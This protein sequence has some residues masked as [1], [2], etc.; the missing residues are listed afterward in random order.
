MA[1]TLIHAVAVLVLTLTAPAVGAKDVVIRWHG[2]SFFEITSPEGLRIV[3]DPHAIEEY[4]R[5]VVKGDLILMSHLHND[6]TQVGVVED[7][8]KV[9]QINALKKLDDLGQRTTWNLVDE[10]VKDVKFRTVGTYHDTKA[11]MERGK[12]GVW[13]LEVAGLKIVHLGDLGHAL[14][15]SQ[16]RKIGEVDVLM[17][18]VGGV[19]TING[20]DA[21]KVCEQLKPKRYV[22]PMHYGTDVYENLLSLDK[23]LFLDDQ[24]IGEVK[25]FPTTN[26]LRIDP[27]AKPPA[28]PIIAILN[29]KKAGL[30]GRK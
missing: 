11:G 27:K 30:P 6:H 22:I 25:R 26:E 19:Y 9:R 21:Q 3:L 12:N 29:W 15:R 13:I 5:I 14:T 16:I 8:R 24:E 4:G 2:Q 18:P 10:K 28:K 1:R 23:S 17:I 7:F 20:L